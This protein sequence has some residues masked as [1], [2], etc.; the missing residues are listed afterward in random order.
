MQA[1]ARTQEER[2]GLLQIGIYVLTLATGLIHLVVLNLLLGNLSIPFTLNGLG[3]LALL[4]ALVL[5]IPFLR[6]NRQLVKYILMGFAAVTIL[7]WI[8]I[9]RPYTTLG[10]ITKLIELTLIVLLFI[11]T[12]G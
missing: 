3:Y 12:R 7:A 4:A 5:P 10:Y 6:A 9:G 2:I 11:D 1:R 8:I